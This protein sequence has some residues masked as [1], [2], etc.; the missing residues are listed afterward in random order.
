MDD[1]NFERLEKL[2]KQYPGVEL[3]AHS[4]NSSGVIPLIH[5]RFVVSYFI[6]IQ[7]KMQLKLKT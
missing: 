1:E 6:Q 7:Q 4:S 3:T 5:R 2:A